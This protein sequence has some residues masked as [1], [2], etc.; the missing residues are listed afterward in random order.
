MVL[1]L[2]YFN[3]FPYLN[4]TKLHTETYPIYLRRFTSKLYHYATITDISTN[5]TDINRCSLYR[6]EIGNIRTYEK[7]EMVL[8]LVEQKN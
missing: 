1:T 8:E 4:T 7:S 2:M 6:C 3:H 5:V